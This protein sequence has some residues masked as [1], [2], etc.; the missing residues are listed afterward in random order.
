M[1]SFGVADEEARQRGLEVL[2]ADLAA[3]CKDYDFRQAYTS[4]FIRKRLEKRGIHIPSLEECL[5]DLAE[6]G[7]QRVLVQPSHLTPGEE[8]NN[9]ILGPIRDYKKGFASLKIGEP[10]FFRKGEDG[11]V[12]DYSL[13]LE[14]VWRAMAPEEGEELVLLGHGS[15]HWHNP[16]YELL[17]ARADEKGIPLHIGVVEESD[18]PNFSMVLERLKKKGSLRLL[19]A[20]L[21]LSG[22]VHVTEDMA[23]EEPGSWKSRLEKAGFSLRISREGLGEH[24]EIRQL[25][26]EKAKRLLVSK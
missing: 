23:G 12:D 14:A 25:Y 3:L 5:R 21:L 6:G 15:P 22:G 16:V 4:V 26:L 24:P 18:T 17:Q 1:T 9:K 8:Y 19:L 7:Y 10:L 2:A 20:P 11:G 13:G